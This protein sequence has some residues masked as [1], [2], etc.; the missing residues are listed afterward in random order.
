MLMTIEER[1]V[2]AQ[3]AL[4]KA[5][6]Q[7]NPTGTDVE[8]QY[9]E[10]CALLVDKKVVSASGVESFVESCDIPN[11]VTLPGTPASRKNNGVADNWGVDESAK[12]IAD[13]R[14]ALIEAV[15]ESFNLTQA[16]AEIWVEG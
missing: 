7:F 10:A 12:K 14:K 6:I 1:L 8:S 4:D 11:T 2:K 5:S 15:K 16:E 13:N 9:K 3:K